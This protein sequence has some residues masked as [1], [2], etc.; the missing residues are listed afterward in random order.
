MMRAQLEQGD[1]SGEEDRLHLD[2]ALAKALEDAGDF[3]GAFA[4]YA[5]GN[6]IRKAQLRHSADDTSDQAAR[7]QALLDRTFFAARRGSGCPARDPI[8]IVGLPRSGSTLIEQILASHS[9]IEGT[10][11]L[12]D[13]ITIVRRLDRPKGRGEAGLYPE[14]LA[15]LSADA[16][17]D[18]GEEYLERTRIHRRTDRPMFIDKLPNNWL[19]VGLIQLILPNATLI[20]ARRHPLG[21]CPVRLQAAFRP[22]PEPSA[23]AFA[24]IGQAITATTWP[25]MAHFDAVLPGKVHRVIYERMVADTEGEVRRLLS[26]VGLPF[27]DG[28]LGSGPTSGPSAPPAPSKCASRSSTMRSTTGATSSR[29]LTRSSRRS[30]RCWT[31]T[32]TSPPASNRTSR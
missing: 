18:L 10:M 3:A 8:L 23:T 9:Q 13:L 15:D 30:V 12:P 11:E 20:D 14:V 22:R 26:H 31:P 24:D 21:C 29:G 27:E 32:P 4:E 17:R 19:H 25:L 5:T 1:L 16:L 7:S 6:A 2:F 28:C